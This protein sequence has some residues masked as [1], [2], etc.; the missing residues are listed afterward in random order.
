MPYVLTLHSVLFHPIK[1]LK[2][3]I[4]FETSHCFQFLLGIDL[5]PCNKSHSASLAS[6]LSYSK[7]LILMEWDDK[8]FVCATFL[9]CFVCN[10]IEKL[11]QHILVAPSPVQDMFSRVCGL[12][13]ASYPWMFNAQFC[14]TTQE[15]CQNLIS[16]VILL[17]WLVLQH[18]WSY[19]PEFQLDLKNSIDSSWAKY[20]IKMN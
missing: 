14:P 10:T 16:T 2:I 4:I 17:Y 9:R 8:F 18:W 20:A 12:Y 11:V 19:C 3:G 13:E 1:E 6:E 15:V 5:W 7:D